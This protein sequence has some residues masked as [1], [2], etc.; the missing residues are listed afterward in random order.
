MLRIF[1]TCLAILNA[2]SMAGEQADQLVFS[3]MGCGPYSGD[4]FKAIRHYVSEENRQKGSE[5]LIHL[6]DI[7][8]GDMAR[9]GKLTEAHYLSIKKL[10]TRGNQIPT[11]IIPGDNEWNDRPD[12]ET[13]WRHW[14]AHLGSL[15]KNYT[16]KWNTDRQ[17]ARPENFTFI[18]SGVLFIGI[19]L[20]GGRIHDRKEWARRFG[21]NNDWIE[22][23]FIKHRKTVQVAVV[24]CHANPIR[25]V[26]GK[27]QARPPFA[28]FCDRF[29]KLGAAFGKPVL[30]LHA[31]GHQ[32]IVDQPWN[33]APNITRI[34]LDRVNQTF[35]PVQFTI[36]PAAKKP[37]SFDR[38]LK[39]PGW[40]F[41]GSAR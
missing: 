8:S 11:Y 35:P 32:W 33:N 27:P 22:T 21:E 18:K 15:E 19:N 9:Q 30:F 14:T 26:K 39:K 3:A 6:G 10:L 31:D 5:F 12:P 20:V 13:G 7:N 24:C 2:C 17:K 4:D 28:P 23:Q 1:V 36:R 37:F 40:K 41:P 38:R 25:M 16:V 29:A 34:Q